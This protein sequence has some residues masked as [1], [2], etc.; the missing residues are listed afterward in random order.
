MMDLIKV[1]LWLCVM[2]GL[3]IAIIAFIA[4]LPLWILVLAFILLL[5][6]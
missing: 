6:N 3:I 2:V 1:F 4:S 5:M